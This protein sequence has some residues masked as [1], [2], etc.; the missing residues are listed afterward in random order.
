MALTV[1]I[2]NFSPVPEPRT[3]EEALDS[4]RVL[5][6]S[7]RGKEAQRAAARWTMQFPDSAKLAKWDDV[8]T[9]QHSE[10]R[11]GTGR[12]HKADDA[13]IRENA[14]KYPGNWMALREGVLVAM[15]QDLATVRRTVREL[16]VDPSEVLLWVQPRK[17]ME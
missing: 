5:L 4:M 16:G 11:P 6:E 2:P 7:G 9:Y 10:Y 1:P 17:P 12:D 8:L 13:W 15:D 3:E 14:P